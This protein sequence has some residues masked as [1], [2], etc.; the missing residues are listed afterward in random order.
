MKD[1]C[2]KWLNIRQTLY[3]MYL[4]SILE[5]QYIQ[6]RLHIDDNEVA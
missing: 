5:V 6:I 1:N 4:T 2:E 3:R